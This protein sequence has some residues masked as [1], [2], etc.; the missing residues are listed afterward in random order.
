MFDTLNSKYPIIAAAMNKVSDLNLAIA[1]S[2][3]G[4][5]ASISSFNYMNNDRSIRFDLLSKDLLEFTATTKSKNLILS[6]SMRMLD[7][8][9]M[10]NILDE[11]NFGAIEIVDWCPHSIQSLSAFD[12]PIILKTNGNN[13]YEQIKDSVIDLVDAIVI[14]GPLGAGLVNV[15][16]PLQETFLKLKENHKEIIIIP[17]GGISTSNDVCEFLNLGAEYV[18][19]GTLFAACTES[20]ISIEAK[21]KIIHSSNKDIK[22]LDNS[23]QNAIYFGPIN[24]LD[25]FNNTQSLQHGITD[26]KSGH[27]FAGAAINNITEIESVNTVVQRLVKNLNW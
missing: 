25:D 11:R 27:I 8:K 2:N 16:S 12:I 19:I 4:I 13:Y 20:R 7:I 26:A 15:N 3:A 21:Q 9:E 10:Q 5:V 24:K 1:C 22:F 23:T 14:K 6:T 18:A 17:S